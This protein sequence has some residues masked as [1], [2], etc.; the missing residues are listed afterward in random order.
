MSRR[1]RRLVLAALL[2][3]LL[4]AATADARPWAWLGVRIRDL[5][6][7]E[8]D[9]VAGRHGIGE[10]FGVLIV[11]VIEDTPAARSG[12]RAGDI[13]VAY[14]GRPVTD[15]RL[16]QRLIARA[17]VD[18]DVRLTVLRREGRTAVPVRLVTMPRPV[19]GERIAAEFGFVLREA[20]SGAGP[21]LRPPSSA[22]AVTVVVRGGAAE[23]AGLEVG[24]VI[25]QVNDLAVL[26]RDAARE[27]LGGLSLEGPLRLTV[28][29]DSQ[30]V[31]LTL[32]APEDRA[33][34]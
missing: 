9:D 24:D 5:S 31:S 33:K 12:M 17:P 25:L 27:A 11:E 29:R 15:T 23:K 21:G 26:T 4:A 16:L 30:H 18:G 20:E 7:Q 34:P 6:E 28:R 32:A 13:V 2:G 8:M 19:A 22:P 14:E 3:L 10:G 1:R